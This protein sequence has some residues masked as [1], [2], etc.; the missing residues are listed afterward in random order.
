[1]SYSERGGGTGRSPAG[2]SDQGPLCPIISGQP[3]KHLLPNIWSFSSSFERHPFP[4]TSRSPASSVPTEVRLIA[5]SR[6]P[7]SSPQSFPGSLKAPS[8]L[9]RFADGDT[10]RGDSREEPLRDKPHSSLRNPPLA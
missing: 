10:E 8:S 1:M 4:L 6:D 2:P 9:H 7:V 3:S 5:H